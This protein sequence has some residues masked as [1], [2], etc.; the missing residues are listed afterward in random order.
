MRARTLSALLLA[1]ALA[2]PSL[3]L[4]AEP[5]KSEKESEDASKSRSATLEDKIPPV[6][7]NLFWKAGRFEIAPA[8]GMSLGDAFFQKYA[9]G[10]MLDYHVTET[11]AV[12]LHGSYLLNTAGNV[13]SVCDASGGCTAPTL[14]RLDQVPGSVSLLAGLEVA[15]SPFYG[16]VNVLAEKVLHFDTSIFAG[17]DLIM[18][19]AYNGDEGKNASSLT[20]GGH[21]GI[22]QRI[23]F[24][25]SVALR[26]ELR[27]YMYSASIVP[28]GD[29]TKKSESKFENQLMLEFGISFFV[30][31][32]KE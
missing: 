9:F 2:A 11:V 32:S 22:G 5:A 27:D 29:P 7:G 19:G 31:G 3:A 23:V 25:Q 28:I 26:I 24:T 16:K 14:E 12:G 18:Y 20:A 13:V 17:A 8:I 1:G 6:S 21:V 4:A 15:W 30:G 10:L